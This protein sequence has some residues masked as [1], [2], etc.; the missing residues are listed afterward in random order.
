MR[1]G[2][3]YQLASIYGHFGEFCPELFPWEDVDTLADALSEYVI[4]NFRA[5]EEQ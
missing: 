3:N 4:N 5:P 1:E 2:L